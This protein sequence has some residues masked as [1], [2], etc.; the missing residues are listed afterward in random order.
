MYHEISSYTQILSKCTCKLF[1][2]IS[3]QLFRYQLSKKRLRM[4][5]YNYNKRIHLT[6]HRNHP[7]TL[8]RVVINH[9]LNIKRLELLVRIQ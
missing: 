5:N 8:M 3:K 1:M 7:N 6:V 2:T 4:S 9:L